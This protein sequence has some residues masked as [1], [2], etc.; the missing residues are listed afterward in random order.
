MAPIACIAA[1][2]FP[3]LATAQRDVFDALL[4]THSQEIACGVGLERHG[5]RWC[6]T[7]PL[8]LEVM[9]MDLIGAFEAVGVPIE[10]VSGRTLRVQV[11][12][13]ILEIDLWN[14]FVAMR[15]RP[16]EGH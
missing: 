13:G 12:D 15:D 4:M 11:P 5:Y 1:L 14:G 2:G 3:T 8:P 9:R 16:R 6:A 7:H 10:Q